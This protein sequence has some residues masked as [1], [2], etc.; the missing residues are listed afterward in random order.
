MRMSNS[1]RLISAILAAAALATPVS[2]SAQT[3]L[4]GSDLVLPATAP[5]NADMVILKTEATGGINRFAITVSNTG[6]VAVTGAIVTDT[7]GLNGGCSKT[8][9][10]SITGDGIP[11]G[12]FTVAN[13]NQPGIALGTL[14]P[15]QSAT[16][17][18]SC[19]GK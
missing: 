7:G 3:A 13:L 2:L 15:G 18:Y 9:A 16:L 4:F 11:E 17:T 8:N 19:Q 1:P 6:S 5:S 10:V 12:S 14:Q